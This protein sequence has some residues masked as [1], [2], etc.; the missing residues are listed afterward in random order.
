[1]ET[2]FGWIEKLS[3]DL[4]KLWWSSSC[5]LKYPESEV[6][7]ELVKILLYGR[8]I[9]GREEVT[10][11]PF[12]IYHIFR[13]QWAL[14]DS[15]EMIAQSDVPRLASTRLHHHHQCKYGLGVLKSKTK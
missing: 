5:T 6:I 9:I 13:T 14:T 2:S 4:Q 1:M 3:E 15:R 12:S 8:S 7:S 11:R 10:M